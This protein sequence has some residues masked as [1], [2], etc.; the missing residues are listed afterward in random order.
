MSAPISLRML[1]PQD[2]ILLLPENP[3][4]K[5]TFEKATI[6][7]ENISGGKLSHNELFRQFMERER[8]GSTSIGFFGAIP[9]VHVKEIK[10]PL[11]VLV[12]LKNPI[13]YDADN[14]P[15]SAVHT[16]FFVVAPEDN[17]K[18]HLKLLAM[19]SHLLADETFMTQIT[20]CGD[21]KAVHREIV[22]WE[23]KNHARLDEIWAAE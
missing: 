22:E 16:L 21:A 20:G 15:T 8:Q 2:N 6:A 12:R 13:Q 3:N 1:L 18:L 17:A 4:K 10:K 14:A 5:R 7:L 23:R 19:F 11:C 9:H